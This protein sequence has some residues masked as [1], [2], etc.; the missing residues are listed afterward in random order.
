[1]RRTFLKNLPSVILTVLVLT[2]FSCK[3][4]KADPADICENILCPAVFK[5]ATIKAKDKNS[6]PYE[7]DN[8]YTI[9]LST[10][11]EI[12]FL[13]KDILIDSIRRANGVYP[14]LSDAQMDLTTIEGVDF[15]FHGFKDGKEVITETYKINHNCCNI[16]ILSGPLEITIPE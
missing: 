2:L 4:K 9:E 14:V 6:Q 16:K 10:G 1:M 5:F 13:G 11:K 7:L 12:R 3:N 8:F 15:Q